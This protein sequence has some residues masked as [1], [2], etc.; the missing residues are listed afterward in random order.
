LPS[1]VPS[2]PQV[3]TS[4]AGHAVASRGTPPAGTKL[5]VPGDPWTL[6]D[7]QLSVQAVLQHTPSTQVPLWQSL[8]QPQASPFILLPLASP[9]VQLIDPSVLPSLPP[10]SGVWPDPLQPAAA[11]AIIRNAAW[12]ADDPTDKPLPRIPRTWVASS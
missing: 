12:N 2:R 10:P 5:Q 8:A 6:Q 3:D 7:L 1:Q 9:L 4:D 11:I